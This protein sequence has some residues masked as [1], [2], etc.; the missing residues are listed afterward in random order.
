MR[1]TILILTVF[2]LLSSCNNSGKNDVSADTT[3]ANHKNLPI[4]VDSGS[5]K[6]DSLEL[7]KLLQNVYKWHDQNQRELIDYDVITKD[8][9][10]IGLNYESFN[11]TFDAIKKTDYFSASFLNNYQQIGEYINNKLVKANPK[12]LN[13]INF[14]YQESDPWTYFQDEAHNFWNKF[15]IVDFKSFSNTASLNWQTQFG[16]YLSEKYAVKFVKENGN[17]KV[18][19]M[20]GFDMN[21]YYQ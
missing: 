21:K 9:F 14:A 19:Y 2:G 17:W 5:D 10:Q 16:D 4:K 13:E 6:N 15:K 11:K 20:E 1:Q 7:V 3:S 18:S 8:S 12:Y